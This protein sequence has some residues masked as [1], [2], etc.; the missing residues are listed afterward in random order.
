M[1][2]DIVVL[3]AGMVG[4]SAAL[5]LAER[6]H[7]VTLLDR[8]APGRETSYGNAGIIQREA[9][10]PYAFPRDWRVLLDVALKRG[11]DVNYHLAA[12]P[13]VAP[14]LAAYWRAS[15][16]TSHARIAAE[17]SRLIAHCL[18][19]HASLIE[20]ADA[21]DLVAK[22]GF[23]L[24]FRTE[25]A[26]DDNVQR[27]QRIEREYGVRHAVLDGAGLAQA[28]PALRQ[29]LAGALHWLD[30]W[31]V[32]DPG[33]LVARY[34]RLLQRRGGR[35][36]RSEVRGLAPH[37]GGWRVRTAEAP[38]DAQH[39][40]VALGPWAGRFIEPLG[41]R[42]PLFVKR[43][44]HRHYTGGPTLSMPMLD[45]ERGYVLVPAAQGMRLTTGAEF[46]AD[47]APP[48]PV[49]LD[50]AERIA[51]ELLDLPT[52]VEAQPWMGCRPCTVDM[53]PV[54]GPAPRHTGLWFDFGHAHQGFT[55]GPASGRL[56]ADLID[57]R[58]PYVDPTPFAATRF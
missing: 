46:A 5:H 56:I 47:D 15:S 27:A 37:A 40:V 11:A 22:K 54:I 38:I 45:A 1:A 30:P 42:L 26:L 43:G 28:E 58:T 10:E 13:A 36:L 18:S 51:R 53:K 24:A 14:R 17:Y 2:S 9:V 21:W 7:A 57:G 48:T 33:E 52:P 55:L 25:E 32:D 16:P 50:K 31:C 6:G 19:E 49:Q 20:A 29:R 34:A 23:R 8:V 35:V 41:Y 3:G 4:V 39:V 44:Y 12:M